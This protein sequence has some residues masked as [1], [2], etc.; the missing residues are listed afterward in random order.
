MTC[1]RPNNA[2]LRMLYCPRNHCMS[3]HTN[4]C[5]RNFTKILKL[6]TLFI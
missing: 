4:F 2:K 3:N 5:L 1:L 6:E